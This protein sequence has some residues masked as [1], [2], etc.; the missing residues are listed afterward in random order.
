[1]TIG[2]INHLVNTYHQHQNPADTPYQPPEAHHPTTINMEYPDLVEA[3]RKARSSGRTICRA[4]LVGGLIMIGVFGM[5][6]AVISYLCLTHKCYV[7]NRHLISSA[8]LGKVLTISQVASHIA[9]V[10]IPLLMG[11]ASYHLAAKWLKASAIEGSDRP[12]PMQLGLMLSIFNSANIPSLFSA[13]RYFL[14]FGQTKEQKAFSSPSIRRRS[15]VLLFSFLLTAYLISGSDA[16]LHVTSEA[17]IIESILPYNSPTGSE[18]FG[19]AINNAKCEEAQSAAQNDVI[20]FY[21]N[22]C[23]QMNGGSAGDGLAEMPG[24]RT[25]SNSSD[26][27]RIVY[28]DDQTAIVVPVTIPSNITY[29]TST[30]GIKSSCRSITKECLSP[31]VMDSGVLDYGPNTFLNIKC[32][33]ATKFNATYDFIMKALND[34]GNGVSGYNISSN[35]FHVGAVVTSVAYYDDDNQVNYDKCK[36]YESSFADLALNELKYTVSIRPSVR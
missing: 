10:T 5:G 26:T 21:G 14:G 34:T 32:N 29:T 6:L 24:I 35:P 22:T 16:W 30:I 36:L 19:R 28:A 25:L 12:S 1:M 17:V 13:L 18:L 33:G 15:T 27:H 7:T 3:Q 9:P 20:S 31:T 2:I 11:L 4:F 23:G 8:S